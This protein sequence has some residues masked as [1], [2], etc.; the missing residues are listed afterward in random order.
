[1][2]QRNVFPQKFVAVKMLTANTSY[3]IF[4]GIARE[5]DMLNRINAN[6]S[7]HAG[8][9]H[10]VQMLGMFPEDSHHGPHVCVVTE[11]LG[12]NLEDLRRAINNRNALPIALA[13]RVTKQK[14]Q[15]LDFL[16][17]T[18]GVVHTGKWFTL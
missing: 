13:K 5:T 14:L 10:C 6:R 3:N 16:H 9:K 12:G 15:A 1:M 11:I 7:K 8:S 4:Q 2:L 18:C 17:R